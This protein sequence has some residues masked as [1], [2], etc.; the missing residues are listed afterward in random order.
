MTHNVFLQKVDTC[1]GL[2][3]VAC[4]CYGLHTSCLYTAFQLHVMRS[5]DLFVIFRQFALLVS[6]AQAET[7]KPRL[8]LQ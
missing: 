8:H 7:E 3:G 1:S 4:T 6:V 2:A 5:H